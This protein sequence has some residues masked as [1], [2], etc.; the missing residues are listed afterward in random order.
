MFQQNSGAFSFAPGTD[1]TAPGLFGTTTF[2]NQFG[3]QIAS[4]T[5]NGMDKM[6][7]IANFGVNAASLFNPAMMPLA[8]ASNI[9]KYTTGQ[10]LQGAQQ[11]I[12]VDNMLN[13]SF[14]NRDMGGNFGMGVSRDGARQFTDSMRNLANIPEMMTNDRELLSTFQKLTDMKFFQSSKNLKEM[15]SKFEKA[16]KTMRQMSMD[17][18]KSMEDMAPIMQQAIQSG[19]FSFEDIRRNAAQNKYTQNVGIGF[20]E[21]RI[22]GL[23]QYGSSAFR[24]M[25]GKRKLGA[26]AIRDVAGKLSVAMQHGKLNE[27][28]LNEYTGKQ[29]EDAVIDV[30]QQ[31]VMGN[32]RLLQQTEQGKLITAYLAEQDKE[33]KFTGKIDRSKLESMG[34]VTLKEMGDIVN[35][36][37]KTKEG[38]ISFVNEMQKGL[39]ANISSQLGAGGVQDVIEAITRGNNFSHEQKR[40]LISDLGGFE[41]QFTDIL[42]DSAKSMKELTVEYQRQLDQNQNRARLASHIEYRSLGAWLSRKATQINRV[43]AKPLQAMGGEALNVIGEKADRMGMAIQRGHW[44]EFGKEFIT[45]FTEAGSRSAYRVDDMQKQLSEDFLMGK[46]GTSDYETDLLKG[47]GD[48][49]SSFYNMRKDADSGIFNLTDESISDIT[50][51]KGRISGRERVREIMTADVQKLKDE[52]KDKKMG[53]DFLLDVFKDAVASG[54]SPQDIIKKLVPIAQNV[55]IDVGAFLRI[56]AESPE[57][58]DKYS[59]QLQ[60]R[61]IELAQSQRGEIDTNVIG[62]LSV[63]EIAKLQTEISDF[64]EEISDEIGM[65][66]GGE[67][68]SNIFR[69]GGGSLSL[70]E[71]LLRATTVMENDDE[72]RT[73]LKYASGEKDTVKAAKAVAQIF[74]SKGIH[75]DPK[76]L[77]NDALLEDIFDLAKE[78]SSSRSQAAA[79]AREGLKRVKKL[80]AANANMASFNT[81]GA[82]NSELFKKSKLSKVIEEFNKAGSAGEKAKILEDNIELFKSVDINRLGL[83]PNS[84]MYKTLQMQKS[85]LRDINDIVKGGGSADEK[86]KRLLEKFNSDALRAKYEKSSIEEIQKG[87]E[88]QAIS[89]PAFRNTINNQD[90][91]KIRD[92]E[93]G[94]GKELAQ[95]MAS[96]SQQSVKFAEAV[97]SAIETQGKFNSATTDQI[98]NLKD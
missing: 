42:M 94:Y 98:K 57:Y 50:N 6:M 20:S 32:A 3:N 47:S 18:N 61:A 63:K 59:G 86:K 75:I 1:L 88:L 65:F 23:Q 51:V 13:R 77:E 76:E 72:F 5:L 30:A 17:L 36:K 43:T 2:G 74:K 56:V 19:F 92:Q 73:A 81:A 62:R 48:K 16:V 68:F 95:S 8:I 40:K 10:F 70:Q 22:E 24:S 39:G 85:G 66:V 41:M 28:S 31:I 45:P 78:S 55:G 25:G 60:A 52:I 79:F 26:E 82:D 44:G 64:G 11:Q 27:E 89:D 37:L 29:G 14:R 7:S 53:M 80:K 34:N 93:Y 21:G 67:A 9:G 84:E 49:Y 54:G 38:S 91:Q 96:V 12:A 58:K 71:A 35:E 83:D 90:E 97:S 46:F 87:L 69:K 15:T 4:N 33:G